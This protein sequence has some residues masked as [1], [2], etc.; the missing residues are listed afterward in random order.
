DAERIERLARHWRNLLAGVLA[1]PDCSLAEL[2]LLDAEERHAI[3]ENLND[4]SQVY[5]GEVCVQRHF[6]AHAAM[7]GEAT[8]LVFQG[9]TLSYA[10]LNRRANRLAHHLRA[11]G[12]GP[13]ELVGIACERSLEMVIGLL[14]ILKAGGAY[15]P[16]DPE[17]PSE[18]L[19]Y[20]ID[21]SGI[22]LLLTQEHL[23][24]P[25]P[26]PDD[27][28]CVCLNADADWLSALPD[29]DLPS[30]ALAENLAYVIYTSGSTGKPKGAGNR[31]VALHN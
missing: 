3:L 26:I 12:V 17:Y 31:H 28:Q 18:R 24:G 2:P 9:Q 1:N 7:V 5:P 21:D 19:A 22:A 14:A 16:L 20:M 15:V 11:Q 8:A 4:T 27:L 13:E 29:H 25:L 10:E 30:V 6:E 23:L